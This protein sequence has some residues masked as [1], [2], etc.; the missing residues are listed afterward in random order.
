MG[1]SAAADYSK[2][3]QKAARA[4]AKSAEHAQKRQELEAQL[5]R[6]KR[7]KADAVAAA[8]LASAAAKT[9]RPACRRKLGR[10]RNRSA[11]FAAAAVPENVA[12][13]AAAPLALAASVADSS[14]AAPEA[15]KERAGR[16]SASPLD[17]RRLGVSLDS[18]LDDHPGAA[19]ASGQPTHAEAVNPR[20]PV[21]LTTVSLPSGRTAVQINR[22]RSRSPSSSGG[23]LSSSGSLAFVASS[24]EGSST[25]RSKS[26]TTASSSTHWSEV[27]SNYTADEG[28]LDAYFRQRQKSSAQ[29]S[30]AESEGGGRSLAAELAR[31]GAASV[32][33]SSATPPPRLG[34][35][36]RTM[37]SRLAS[38]DSRQAT[39]SS[40][41]EVSPWASA[42]RLS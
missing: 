16:R 12:P 41:D 26:T 5:E 38:I 32:D 20:A 29:Q 25:G 39:A 27:P 31:I 24:D 33:S 1:A 15:A 42:G 22:S 8:A 6:H 19:S 10:G 40:T 23:R 2:R 28:A 11:D 13:A 7:E 36:K 18:L 35:R 34:R 14:A 4:S 9:A 17:S 30:E 21:R 37:R 3:Q